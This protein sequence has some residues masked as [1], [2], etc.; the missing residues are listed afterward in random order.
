MEIELRVYSAE[1]DKWSK[2]L[3]G[4]QEKGFEGLTPNFQHKYDS[5]LKH[6]QVRQLI[7]DM[8]TQKQVSKQGKITAARLKASCV[9]VSL[10]IQ[11]ADLEVQVLIQIG[12]EDWREI[13]CYYAQQEV[14]PEFAD[15][16]P[17]LIGSFT[18]SPEQLFLKF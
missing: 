17:D 10:K 1:A 4:R 7:F 11:P 15:I 2:Q 13:R 14:L 12:K 5:W 9:G 3:R 18:N 8:K 16:R 6:G